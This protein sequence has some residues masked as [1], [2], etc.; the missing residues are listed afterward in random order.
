M[1]CTHCAADLAERAGGCRMCG[2]QAPDTHTTSRPPSTRIFS[3]LPVGTPAWPRTVPARSATAS[4]SPSGTISLVP[5]TSSETARSH[6]LAP[7]LLLLLIPLLGAGITYGILYAR[8]LIHQPITQTS[9]SASQ[10][11]QSPT[12]PSTSLTSPTSFNTA[13]DPDLNVSFQYPNGWQAGTP[14][15]SDMQSSLTITSQE[16]GIQFAVLRFNE[17]ASPTI[18]GP[19]DLNERIVSEL[20]TNQNVLQVQPI[21]TITA[22]PHIA[23][24]TW[25]QK[26]GLALLNTGNKVHVNAITV[27]YKNAYYNIQIYTP[28]DI[29]QQAL[30]TYL[31]HMLDSLHFLS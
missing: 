31:Q 15:K 12:N 14:D 3:Y 30:K 21:Q 19:S 28:E 9:A 13:S 5:P 8:G 10:P 16:L 27:R 6:W 22:Q 1:K 18:A 23:G 7:A 2:A 20:S 4:M 26:E 25:E 11:A 17:S 29:Y 24:Q